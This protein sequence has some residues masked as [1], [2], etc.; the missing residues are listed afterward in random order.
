[1][2]EL[3]L[4]HLYIYC[5]LIVNNFTFTGLDSLC[6]PF[7]SLNFNDEGTFWKVLIL[8]QYMDEANLILSMLVLYNS[9]AELY[10]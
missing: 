7:L 2:C 3:N 6:A 10:L 9:I 4:L 8:K 1:M 5:T